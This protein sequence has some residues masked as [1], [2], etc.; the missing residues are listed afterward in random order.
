MGKA[1]V[2]TLLVLV[3]TAIT[4]I[5]EP[6][7]GEA[8]SGELVSSDRE[9][10]INRVNSIGVAADMNDWPGVRDCFAEK[11]ELDYTSM[12]GGEPASL[13]P[14]RIV[15]NWRKIL[16]GFELT[17]HVITNHEVRVKEN[18]GWCFSYVEA[19]HVIPGALNG[20]TWTV[21]G[22]YYHHLIRTPGGWKVDRM[23]FLKT[24]LD[25]NQAL[26][27]LAMKRAE[28]LQRE[29]KF[30]SEGSRLVG[31]LYLPG[32]YKD[33][34]KLPAAIVGGSWT[35]VKE[36]M[37][38]GY[39]REMARLGLAAL[40]FDH[41]GYG[42][43]EGL[44]RDYESPLKKIQD[45]NQ[46]VKCLQTRPEVDGERVGALGVCAGAGYLAVSAALESGLKSLVTVA[47][48][49][50]D[51]TT[52]K[53]IYGGEEG[54]RDKIQ[55]GEKA[56]EKFDKTGQVDY[57]PAISVSDRQ[58]AMFG[59]FDYY[60]N[61]KRG[62]IKAWSNRFAVMAWPEWLKFNPLETASRIKAPVLIIHSENAALPQ[63]ARKFFQALGGPKTI[64]WLDGSHFDYYDHPRYMR[65]AAR[66]AADHFRQT[67]K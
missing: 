38:G 50:H 22:H 47:A 55:V 13:E 6:S 11:V 41:R 1:P 31:T 56:R 29:V 60:L 12:A 10:I 20:E 57:V 52:V 19:L 44:P 46:A 2:L 21:N 36:Q 67:M 24:R 49:L 17:W 37:A 59:E 65:Q 3:L 4:L 61:P 30:E 51:P 23:K 34:K 7:L 62:A 15:E 18:E 42:Q 26:P 28:P 48:W 66:L 25:G 35:T 63:G 9:A 53:L 14:D 45:F 40:A 5:S 27:G 32:D 54:V 16:A 43:S 8:A 58:A 39:A 33:G 64:Q